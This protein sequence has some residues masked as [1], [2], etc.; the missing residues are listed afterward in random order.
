MRFTEV[1]RFTFPLHVRPIS[2][3]QLPRPPIINPP[4]PITSEY[5]YIHI[6]KHNLPSCLV[7]ENHKRPPPAATNLNHNPC[8][9]ETV[10]WS[11]KG[12]SVATRL[13]LGRLL[14]I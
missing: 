3:P 4:M 12:S 1:C 11:L 5:S 9:V 2:P 10:G 7:Y 8:K 13:S 6:N 14:L